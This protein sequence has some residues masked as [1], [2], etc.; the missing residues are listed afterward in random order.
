MKLEIISDVHANYPALLA[1]H[2]EVGEDIST[3]VFAGDAMG[4]YGYP[5]ETANFSK[6]IPQL[7]LK[8]ITTLQPLKTTKG[9]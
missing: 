9:I 1:V 7:E 2:K 4:L 3:Y 5:S 8:E 6:Q